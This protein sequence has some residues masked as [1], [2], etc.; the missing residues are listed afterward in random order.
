MLCRI[1]YRVTITKCS[2]FQKWQMSLPN[3]DF[4][5]LMVSSMK[6][7]LTS[8]Y[9]KNSHL[10]PSF[11]MKSCLVDL[12][13]NVFRI[14]MRLLCVQHYIIRCEKAVN[15]EGFSF[16]IGKGFWV[17]VW[18]NKFEIFLKKILQYKL[19]MHIKDM[20]L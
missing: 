3:I 13:E 4:L 2:I 16:L 17:V 8:N 19:Q 11:V 7:R 5:V 20:F 12:S 18:L 15:F 6:E 14:L 10:F 9:R 1:I